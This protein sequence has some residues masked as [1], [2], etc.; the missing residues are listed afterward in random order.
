M[1][2]GICRHCGIALAAEKRPRPG[3]NRKYC[4]AACRRRASAAKRYAKVSAKNTEEFAKLQRPC[5]SCGK[6][7]TGHRRRYCDKTCANRAFNARRRADGRLAE[8]R[9]RT[10]DKSAA[11]NKANRHRYRDKYRDRRDCIS[12][13]TEFEVR[14]GEPTKACSKPCLTYMKTGSWPQSR[15]P[16]KTC[17]DCGDV[18]IDEGVPRC[19]PCRDIAQRL[20][21]ARKAQRRYQKYGWYDISVER[22]YAIYARDG[23]VCQLCQEPIDKAVGVYDDWSPSLDHIVPRSLGGTHEDS[24]L[25]LAHRWCNSVRGDETYY[26]AEDLAPPTALTA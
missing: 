24:N 13:G 15:I 26:T 5:E 22:R 25:R 12:C 3:P 14:A 11:W 23:W 4:D 19:R 1:A 2:E 16:W 20:Y 17:P 21:L 9:E 6:V 7:L 8:L 18:R 10:K